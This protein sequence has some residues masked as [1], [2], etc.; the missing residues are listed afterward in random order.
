MTDNMIK[1]SCGLI[2][3]ES[4]MEYHKESGEHLV[5]TLSDLAGNKE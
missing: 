4:K 3:A 5:K 2:V 1:C